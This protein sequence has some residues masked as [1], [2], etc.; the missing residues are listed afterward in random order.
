M[1]HYQAMR[2]SRYFSDQNPVPESKKID[3]LA[4][5]LEILKA[6]PTHLEVMDHQIRNLAELEDYDS[7]IDTYKED[8]KALSTDK[9]ANK[10]EVPKEM[11]YIRTQFEKKESME[12]KK[13]NFFGA[14][15]LG[16]SVAI[17]GI[18]YYQWDRTK[19]RLPRSVAVFWKL[20][21]LPSNVSLLATPEVQNQ[22]EYVLSTVEQY[23]AADK[24]HHIKNGFVDQRI[25]TVLAQM[26][27]PEK[28]ADRYL[29]C[30]EHIL[31]DL[32]KN[33]FLYQPNLELANMVDTIR[34]LVRRVTKYSVAHPECKATPLICKQLDTL[35]MYLPDTVFTSETDSV[36][37]L[38]LAHM[39]ASIKQQGVLRIK[40]VPESSA[41]TLKK[42]EW[43]LGRCISALNSEQTAP[44]GLISRHVK[45]FLLKRLVTTQRLV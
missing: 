41:Q 34:G 19:I 30:L 7:L 40:E 37:R 1:R 43:E 18:C 29:G 44:G 14:I 12:I 32:Q 9:F 11:L 35:L 22:A 28:L 26:D 4:R 31:D 16:I 27:I 23:V 21:L 15:L 42:L 6:S 39:F 20:R 17:C 25:M 10:L 2:M 38:E 5:K 36:V 3:A 45:T 13:F 33:K 24:E 8:I